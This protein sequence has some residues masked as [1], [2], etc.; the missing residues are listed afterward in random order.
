MAEA[1]F[2]KLCTIDNMTAY[3]AGLSV[4]SSSKT[5]KHSAAIVNSKL[6]MDI[7]NRSSVQL[8][9][10][11]VKEADLILTMT[12]YMRD[13][14]KHNFPSMSSKI[15][16][17][18]EYVGVGGDVVDPYGGDISIY[19]ETFKVLK[20]SIELLLGKLKGDKSTI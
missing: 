16:M 15:Y 4:V 18:N 6:N 17:L 11:L 8:T 19:T 12:A 7:S 9:E 13:V 20:T 10:N 14:L 5:S 2:N 1:I 3:S